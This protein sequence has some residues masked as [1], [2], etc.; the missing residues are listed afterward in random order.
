MIGER[1]SVEEISR[2]YEGQWVLL[3]DPEIFFRG[4]RLA[5]DFD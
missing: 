2:R 1:L 5:L 3:G 4:R